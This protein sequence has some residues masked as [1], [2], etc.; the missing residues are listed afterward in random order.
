MKI[1]MDNFEINNLSNYYYLV[2]QAYEVNKGS[3]VLAKN[4]NYTASLYGNQ[5]FIVVRDNNG[6]FDA[7]EGIKFHVSVNPN[8][9]DKAWKII[10]EVMSDYGVRETKFAN[11]LF[12]DK[13]GERQEGGREIAIYT[14]ND[15]GRKLYES[16]DK[17]EKS[18]T[19]TH[20]NIMYKY[21]D[22]NNIQPSWELIIC[23][24]TKRLK[25]AQIQPGVAPEG[26]STR[27]GFE[28]KI[29]GTDYITWRHSS[30]YWEDFKI[31]DTYKNEFI[32]PNVT[33]EE[34]LNTYMQ[35]IVGDIDQRDLEAYC[36]LLRGFSHISQKL[37]E[38]DLNNNELERLSKDEHEE[39]REDNYVVLRGVLKS[40]HNI[41]Q[42]IN[43]TSEIQEDKENR[44][45]FQNYQNKS[46]TNEE[47][48]DINNSE[49]SEDDPYGN[50]NEVD[51]LYRPKD[52]RRNAIKYGPS[53]VS[54]TLSQETSQ[55]NISPRVFR[56]NDLPL[57]SNS[58]ESPK[59]PPLSSKPKRT[60][61][62]P[63]SPKL[64]ENSSNN[65]IDSHPNV[66]TKDD[67][68]PEL[69]N[70][71]NFINLQ[72]QQKISQ[73]NNRGNNSQSKN[74]SNNDSSKNVTRNNSGIT[75]KNS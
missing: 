75:R 34:L 41:E 56:K 15:K 31:N 25:E 29:I 48:L 2:N 10:M 61:Q 32:P 33:N 53:P 54:K 46:H 59:P 45:N 11:P 13:P 52:K 8:Q 70:K 30:P 3:G 43:I 74:D 5:T 66:N 9:I 28:H 73:S 55:N 60:N 51:D 50:K 38:Q 4:D 65:Y 1:D 6:G 40:K 67:K 36:N 22:L 37:L 17:L 62:P 23:E 24:M 63:Q 21:F 58:N 72:I 42:N 16:Q 47:I 57:N 7:E 20:E 27:G 19:L 39:R 64:N 26:N 68:F 18:E 14:H 71:L 49:S 44:S 12:V 69:V 35:P